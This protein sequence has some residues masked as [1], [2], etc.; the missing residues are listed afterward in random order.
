MDLK[1]LSGL[2]T[3]IECYWVLFLFSFFANHLP[4]L[5]KGWRISQNVHRNTRHPIVSLSHSQ[6]VNSI[7]ISIVS[8]LNSVKHAYVRMYVIRIYFRRSFLSWVLYCT[9]FHDIFVIYF[10]FFKYTVRYCRLLV[11][12]RNEA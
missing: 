12:Y 2:L 8:T 3:I 5:N 1:Y 11:S 6:I 4:Q 10:F 7:Y 9:M